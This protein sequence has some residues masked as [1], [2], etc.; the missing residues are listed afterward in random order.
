M[1]YGLD[2]KDLYEVFGCWL[3]FLY[4]KMGDMKVK[5]NIYKLFE[6]VV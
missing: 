3:W 6:E 5:E 2:C 1:R 4:L